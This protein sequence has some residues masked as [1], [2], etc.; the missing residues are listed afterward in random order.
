[1]CLVY[2]DYGKITAAAKQQGR[3][4]RVYNAAHKLCFVHGGSSG[5]RVLHYCNSSGGSFAGLKASST[6]NIPQIKLIHCL[7]LTSLQWTLG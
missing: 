3:R 1:M 4:K 5:V 7:Q 2:G 6:L